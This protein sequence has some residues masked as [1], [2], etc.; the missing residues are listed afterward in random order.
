[1]VDAF[2]AANLRELKNDA[3]NIH[4]VEYKNKAVLDFIDTAGEDPFFVYYSET[5][6]HGP[7]PYWRRNGEYYAGLDADVNITSE[8]VLTQ[9]YSYLPSRDQIK[10]EINGIEGKDPRHAWLRW[11]DHAVGAVVD[12]LREKGKLENTLLIITSDHGDLN[13]GKATNYEGGIKVPLMMYW[14]NGIATTGT[15][16][17]LVQNIDFAPTFLDIAGVRYF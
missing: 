17:E 13:H 7:A 2:Y 12:K 15:Y 11:F 4:N 8:G 10:S 3:L 9:D 6:P 1:M 5:I 14:K 16:D